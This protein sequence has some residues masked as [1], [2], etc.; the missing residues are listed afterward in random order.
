MEKVRRQKGTTSFSC[1]SFLFSKFPKAKAK[2]ST[3]GLCLKKKKKKSLQLK[4]DKKKG[5]FGNPKPTNQQI[6]ESAK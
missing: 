5:G 3:F 4:L 6:G 2:L 1:D